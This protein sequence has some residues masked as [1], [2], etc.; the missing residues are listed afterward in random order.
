MLG[1][2]TYKLCDLDQ[3]WNTSPMPCNS[4]KVTQG[5]AEWG[6]EPKAHDQRWQSGCSWV[7][8]K[9]QMDLKFRLQN[10]LK[11]ILF[12]CPNLKELGD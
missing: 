9:L 5:V 7:R 6:L 3:L 11:N 10:V 1:V 8:S 4:P 2:V 12:R